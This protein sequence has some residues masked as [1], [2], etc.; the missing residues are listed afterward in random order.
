M[1]VS[2]RELKSRLSEYL[3]RAADGE[4]V[5]VTSRGQ[6]VARLMP[7]RKHRSRITRSGE[8]EA[9]AVEMLQSLPWIR[10]GKT[11]K[12]RVGLDRPAKLKTG[13]KP[14]SETVAEMRD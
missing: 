7:P 8:A 4:E 9:E 5:I 12:Q 2:V 1:E 11:G 3:R 14:I 6:P 10:P 13:A